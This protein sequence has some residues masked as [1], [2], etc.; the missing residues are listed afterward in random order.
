MSLKKMWNQKPRSGINNKTSISE[1]YQTSVQLLNKDGSQ[2]KLVCFSIIIIILLSTYLHQEFDPCQ[3][4]R[5]VVAGATFPEQ[6]HKDHRKI[7]RIEEYYLC[8]LK[9]YDIKTRNAWSLVI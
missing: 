7:R 8:P 6:Q 1:L 4:S 9:I 2:S 3:T 5:K